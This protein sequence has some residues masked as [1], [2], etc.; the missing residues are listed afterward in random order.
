MSGNI[1]VA[2]VII[3]CVA[4][5]AAMSFLIDAL[6]QSSGQSASGAMPADAPDTPE[7]PRG[8]QNDIDEAGRARLLLGVGSDATSSELTLRFHEQVSKYHPDK[9]QHLGVEFQQLAGLKTQEIIRAYQL[10]KAR[11]GK[12]QNK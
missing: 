5:Y 4:G 7:S 3:C 11:Q 12:K 9:T 8:Y 6:R 10:L 1:I 2:V